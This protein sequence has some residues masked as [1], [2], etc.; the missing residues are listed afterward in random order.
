MLDKNYGKIFTGTLLVTSTISYLTLNLSTSYAQ[1]NSVN[2][3]QYINSLK[4]DLV[5][6]QSANQ[7]FS[8]SLEQLNQEFQNQLRLN[9]EFQAQGNNVPGGISAEESNPIL[10][11][12]YQNFNKLRNEND[13]V[14]ASTIPLIQGQEQLSDEDQSK[15]ANLYNTIELDETEVQT[16]TDSASPIPQET[17]NSIE[18]FPA[19]TELGEIIDTF[20]DGKV[21]PPELCN[22]QKAL[23]IQGLADTYDE[24]NPISCG[25]FLAQTNELTQQALQQYSSTLTQNIDEAI[26]II[27]NESA[28]NVSNGQA[29][30]SQNNNGGAN[31]L[32]SVLIGISIICLI[33]YLASKFL[34]EQKSRGR[35]GRRVQRDGTDAN[36]F[37]NTIN[38]RLNNIENQLQAL[39]N[40]PEDIAHLQ[41]LLEAQNNQENN[42]LWQEQYHKLNHEY[43]QLKREL[44]ATKQ[45]LQTQNQD[46]SPN[47][48]TRMPN[49]PLTNPTS[50]SPS[51]FEIT[52]ISGDKVSLTKETIDNVW[53]G[54]T[55][56]IEFTLDSNGEYIVAQGERGEYNL[57]LNP[58]SRINPEAIGIWKKAKL[59]AVKG[60]LQ[61]KSFDVQN[62]VPAKVMKS[63]DGWILTQSGE[64]TL[65]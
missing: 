36:N 14:K 42:D 16:I 59:F 19:V 57:Y 12:I 55:S 3:E 22:I 5:S 34:L 18:I 2:S 17:N 4:T 56:R 49:S 43:Q 9:Q 29:T 54:V 10:E 35:Q 64:I 32:I 20:E 37:E 41:S 47:M 65:A 50:N 30:D 58:N 44:I 25:R 52:N 45:R 33:A 46:P 13:Q 24:N 6:L 63:A 21:S 51:L 23:E 53:K 40:V 60:N 15:L 62:I 31:T 39:T 1:E 7:Q 48:E 38:L 27:D 11:E 61:T 26:A 28:I 8:K